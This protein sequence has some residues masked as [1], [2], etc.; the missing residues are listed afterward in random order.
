[1]LKMENVIH[2]YIHTHTGIYS[3]VA[4]QKG[5]QYQLTEF[6]DLMLYRFISFSSCCLFACLLYFFETDVRPVKNQ[7]RDE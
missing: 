7:K 5:Q 2:K 6:E 4:T 1:M 3:F